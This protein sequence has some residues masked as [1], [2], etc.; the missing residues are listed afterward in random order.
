MAF[1]TLSR[2]QLSPASEAL[3]ETVRTEASEFRERH[4]WAAESFRETEH[5]Q[6]RP[7]RVALATER[8][9]Q[10][11]PIAIRPGE[12]VVGWHPNTKMG[13]VTV[14]PNEPENG[15]SPRFRDI[16]EACAYLRTQTYWVSASEGHMAPDYEGVLREGLGGVLA[17]L[18]RLEAA[19]EPTDRDSAEKHGFYQAARIALQAFQAL[20]RRYADLAAEMAGETDD[21][22]WAAELR[23]MSDLC[24]RLITEPARDLRE[25]VQLMWFMFLGVAV[26]A[27][28]SHHCFGPGRLDQY[29]HPYYLAEREAGT[30]DEGLLRETLDQVLIK[31]NEFAG[32]GMSALIMVVGGRT[33]DGADATNE[34]SWEML[35]A[36]DRVQMYFPGLDVSWHRDMDEEFMRACVRLLRNGKGQPAFFND[37]VIVEGLT[38]LGIPFEH[39]VDHLPSTCTETSIMGR[40][41]PW[42]AW[43]YVNIPQALLWALFDGKNPADDAPQREPRGLPQTCQ[44][45]HDSFFAHMEQSAHEAIAA[46]LREQLVEAWYRPFPLLSCFIQDCLGRGQDISHGG[47]LYNFLQPEAVGVSN[48]VDGL[49]ALRTLVEEQ[50]RFTLDD[51]RA[52][53]QGNFEGH[54]ELRRAVLRDCPKY[55]NDDPW[56]NELFAEVAGGWCSA[57]EGHQNRFGG[58]VLPGFLGWTVWIHFGQQTPATPDGRLAGVPLANSLAPCTGVDL[59]GAPAVL[60]SASQLDHSRG[61]GGMTFNVRFGMNSIATDEGVE[62]LKA[63]IE[64]GFDL[65][66]YQIQITLASAKQMRAAQQAPDEY[67]D[68]FIRVGGYL[69]PFIYLSSDAQEE[70]IARAELEI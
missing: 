41:N 56:L 43:P 1:S 40:C 61:L 53:L 39:A 8:I 15:N 42:V 13:T 36:S 20:I 38:R 58:P 31:C 5:E 65:G 48:V 69:V 9:F 19:L 54:E 14:I 64:A 6:F 30:L 16:D 37:E 67:R 18:E 59:K 4:L 63:L 33:P 10:K 21:A 29:L 11:M 52:A 44:E 24:E 27:G 57:I 46:G 17:R 49:A 28:D 26:E 3:R 68:L 51:F 25:A 47:A 35:A 32:P 70:V 7:I 34:L 23:T 55:G 45:L 12:I 22:E 60:L 50:K 66:T 2:H 62:R